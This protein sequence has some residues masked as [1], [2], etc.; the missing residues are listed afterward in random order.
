MPVFHLLL[1]K[2]QIKIHKNNFTL[3]VVFMGVNLGLFHYTD[4]ICKQ[5]VE[6][7]WNY[8]TLHNEKLYRYFLE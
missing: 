5:S 1:Q 8:R 2:L 3:P 6:N 7:I 4:C